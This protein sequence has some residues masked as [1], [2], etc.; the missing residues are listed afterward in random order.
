MDKLNL[1]YPTKIKTLDEIQNINMLYI[2]NDTYYIKCGCG[3]LLYSNYGAPAI[4]R[5]RFI[6]H[7]NSSKHLIKKC[8]EIQDIKN[9]LS[10]NLKH[11]KKCE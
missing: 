3:K 5:S 8:Y 11:I 10:L 4:I 1:Y 7:N 9:I 6:K 2:L